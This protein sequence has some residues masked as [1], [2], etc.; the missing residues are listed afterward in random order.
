MEADFSCLSDLLAV[1]SWKYAINL[2]GSETM[3][4]TNR[5]LQPFLKP[6]GISRQ[7]RE[8]VMDLMSGSL[9]TIF[10]VSRPMPESDHWRFR[11]KFLPLAAYQGYDPEN[12]C[13]KLPRLLAHVFRS[14]P[15][16]LNLSESHVLFMKLLQLI[17]SAYVE[18]SL[19]EKRG[20]ADP[21]PFNLTIFKGINSHRLPRSWVRWLLT[22]PVPQAK[23][24]AKTK[25]M[26][27]TDTNTG[28]L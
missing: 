26:I 18:F 5:Q 14:S 2:A 8:L 4:A 13:K 25:T 17:F 23:T 24:K 22:H 15:C 1:P 27:V 20:E 10:A 11:N 9:S 3:L 16:H 21:V 19:E 6:L 7:F 12:Q 28:P